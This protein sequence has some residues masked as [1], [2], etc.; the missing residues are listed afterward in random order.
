MTDTIQAAL[1]DIH[2]GSQYSVCA[3]RFWNGVNNNTHSPNDN[4]LQVISH[5]YNFADTLSKHRENKTLKLFLMGDLIEGALLG[6]NEVWTNNPSE[7]TDVAIELIV[8]FKKRVNWQAGDKLYC[9]KGTYR[10]SED[11]E[12]SIGRQ[13]D[14]ET[15]ED[16][17]YSQNEWRVE[18][19]G[20]LT[21]AIHQWVTPGDGANEGMAIY[22]GLRTLYIN[23]LKDLTRHPD[24]VYGAH[25]HKIGYSCYGWRSVN[26]VGIMHG[27]LC[28]SFKMKDRFSA[29]VS[30]FGRNFIG[31]MMQLVT[32]EGVI[33][34]PKFV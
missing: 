18:T 8:D 31:G 4:Q 24:N 28:P 21:W 12:E 20:K 34:S 25:N 29:K 19:N 15:G 17:K 16:G 23:S 10:H 9:L 2:V 7:M 3:N 6:T 22:H 27:T 14:A 32:A 13:L 1:S 33:D 5:F 30:K 26:E 11:W